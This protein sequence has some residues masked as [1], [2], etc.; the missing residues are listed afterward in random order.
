MVRQDP[1]I[2]ANEAGGRGTSRGFAIHGVEKERVGVTVDGFASAPI[3]RRIDRN[4]ALGQ[5]RSSASVNEVEYENLKA[6]NLQKGSSS[7]ESGSG[8]LGGAVSMTTKD[9]SDFFE[10]DSDKLYAGRIKAGYTTKDTRWFGSAAIA[11]R[12]DR[13]EGFIQVTRRHGHEIRAHE[14]LYKGS[15]FLESDQDAALKLPG[16]G[17]WF[18]MADV[19]GADRKVPNP[20]DYDSESVLS[21]FGL[22]VTPEHYVGAVVDLTKQD[23]L[24]KEMTLANFS[25]SSTTLARNKIKK[26]IVSTDIHVGEH[27]TGMLDYTPTMHYVDNHHNNR[28]GLEYRYEPEKGRFI[29]RAKM[30]IDHRNL[31]ISSS[32]YNLNCARWPAVDLNCWPDLE[33]AA[34]NNRVREVSGQWGVKKIADLRE[35]DWRWSG[36]AE[37]RFKLGPT[38]HE[39]KVKS[40]FVDSKYSLLDADIRAHGSRQHTDEATGNRVL[41]DNAIENQT[42]KIDNLRSRMFFVSVGDRMKWKKLEL[43]AGARFDYLKYPNPHPT[44]EQ[45]KRSF[46]FEGATHNNLAWDL[47]VAY[48]VWEPLKLKARVSTGFRFPSVLEQIG[49]SFNI[50]E[51]N[52]NIDPQGPLKKETSITE[53]IGFD[54]VHPILNVSASYFISSFKNVIDLARVDTNYSYYNV[55]NFSTHGFDVK[56]KLDAY[57]LWNKL[58]EGLELFVNTSLTKV[59]KLAPYS[60]RFNIV[61]DYAFDSIQPLR[62]VAGI[63]YN[64][65]S[66][67]WGVSYVNTWSAAKDPSE[68]EVRSK[69]GGLVSQ[70]SRYA[71]MKTQAWA[72]ADLTGYYKPRKNITIRGGIYNLF[73]YKYITWENLR[74]TSFGLDARIATDN[75]VALAAP[76]RNF[77]ISAEIKF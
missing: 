21:K 3:L 27:E 56:A 48:R 23:Y 33:G 7:V 77:Y 40:G 16:G 35:H 15:V 45:R 72:I 39:L 75:F 25:P 68:L 6:V 51:S 9:T 74:Q 10:P 30:E 49:P 19:S 2:S 60:E 54:F 66:E 44:P 65:P 70:G 46:I 11:G 36:E 13:Y 22:L 69:T 29:D 47:G 76:G 17:R 67:K 4:G 64:A 43:S 26:D 8:G 63:N 12:Y 5:S 28:V 14:S 18:D 52:S 32:Y 53:E 42:H 58:P 61:S 31:K 34:K 73:N 38:R 37:K 62:V 55:H 57:A 41:D 24:V 59:R 1:G 50:V 20:M 71:R